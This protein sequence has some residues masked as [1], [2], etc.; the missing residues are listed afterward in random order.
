ML[1]HDGEFATRSAGATGNIDKNNAADVSVPACEFRPSIAPQSSVVNS[2]F[3]HP[4]SEIAESEVEGAPVLAFGVILVGVESGNGA[5]CVLRSE[6]FRELT[7]PRHHRP[8]D[9]GLIAGKEVC[10]DF[11]EPLLELTRL[12]IVVRGCG[13]TVNVAVDQAVSPVCFRADSVAV[14]L[15]RREGIGGGLS[16][17]GGKGKRRL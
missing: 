2:C 1:I 8:V 13:K 3:R 11:P 16:W 14:G 6:D 7:R 17:P 4:G 15:L 5:K 9:L 10:V 12:G